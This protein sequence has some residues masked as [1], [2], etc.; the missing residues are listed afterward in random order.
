MPAKTELIVFSKP[1]KNRVMENLK[2]EVKGQFIKATNSIKYLGV[3]LDRNLTFQEEIKHILRKNGLWYQKAST[4]SEI[5]FPMKT[6]LLLFECSRYQSPTLSSNTF[7]MVYLKNLMTTL[8]KTTET[9]QWKRVFN[10]TKI[11]SSSDLKNTTQSFIGSIFTQGKNL[12]STTGSIEKK[13]IPAFLNEL[14]TT[15][16]W[17]YRT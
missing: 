12:L 17:C 5:I 10:R 3:Y 14:K 7:W 8:E 2:L 1:H 15:Y 13:L 6:R 16:W 9:G 11:E 4:Q